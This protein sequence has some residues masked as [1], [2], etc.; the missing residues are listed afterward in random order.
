MIQIEHET[1]DKI[2]QKSAFILRRKIEEIFAEKK[3]ILLLLS[4]GSAVSLY[5]ELAA[6]IDTLEIKPDFLA[7]AQVDERFHPENELK[8]NSNAI[9]NTK[10]IEKLGIK[11]IPFYKVPQTGTMRESAFNYDKLI[12]KLFGI[13][14]Y[15]IAVLGIGSDGHTAGILRGYNS[16]WEK[17]RFVFGYENRGEFPQRITMTPKAFSF[18]DFGLLV[19]VGG[20]K[21]SALEKILNK[22]SDDIN[23]LPG[24]LIHRIKEVE[25]ITD[26]ILSAKVI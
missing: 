18:L 5:Q 19:A 7:I 21:I 3:R 13:Y 15:K 22:G 1:A 24:L 10:L 14:D 11:G 8:I 17:D 26:N 2:W 4:G 12:K 23:N 6:N 20:E 9:E 16:E 25:V